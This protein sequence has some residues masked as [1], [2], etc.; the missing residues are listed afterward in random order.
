MSGRSF[1]LKLFEHYGPALPFSAAAIVNKPQLRALAPVGEAQLDAWFAEHAC[2]DLGGI[3]VVLAIGYREGQGRKLWRVHG[4]P[5]D[6]GAPAVRALEAASGEP[7]DKI[8]GWTKHRT[9]ARRRSLIEA[10]RGASE[11]VDLRS[12]SAALDRGP[13]YASQLLAQS[14]DLS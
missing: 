7:I 5:A 11:Q 10:V 8:R 6:D 14:G 4:S 12:I 2:R 1:L 3:H 13:N 9:G